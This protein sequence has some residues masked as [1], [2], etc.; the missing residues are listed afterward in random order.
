M[1]QQAAVT[2]A[3]G[4]VSRCTVDAAIP[5]V[6]RNAADAGRPRSAGAQPALLLVG[7]QAT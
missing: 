7:R 5:A 1:R 6:N 4:T 3:A 2:A